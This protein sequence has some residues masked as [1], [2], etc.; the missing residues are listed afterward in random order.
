MEMNKFTSTPPLSPIEA[1]RLVRDGSAIVVI[2]YTAYMQPDETVRLSM[3]SEMTARAAAELY[4]AA[5]TDD[6]KIIAVGEHT[7]GDQY[8]STTDLIY[9]DL[10]R[11]GVPSSACVIER[12]TRADATPQQIAWLADIY[13]GRWREHTPVLVGHGSHWPRMERLCNLYG[14]P[15]TFVDAVQIL[16]AVGALTPAYRRAANIYEAEGKQYE[17]RVQRLTAMTVWLGPAVTTIIFKA[18]ARLR[19][20]NVVEV[21]GFGHHASL[22]A[23][24][25][26][27]HTKKLRR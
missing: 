26:R 8:A 24:T 10:A 15:A 1:E 19:S 27:Q 2:P 14:M 13:E 16:E 12:P 11:N 9:N 6:T 21:V 23:V 20:P 22:Y 25:A 17:Q 4:H 18:L 7:Y 5:A 3:Y